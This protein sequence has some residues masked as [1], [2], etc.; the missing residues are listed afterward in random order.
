M[1]ERQQGTIAA[2]EDGNHCELL[3]VHARAAMLQLGA[4]D[5]AFAMAAVAG[6]EQALLGLDVG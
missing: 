6:L 2:E 3:T 5:M 1:S 4:N